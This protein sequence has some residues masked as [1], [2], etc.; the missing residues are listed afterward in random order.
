MKIFLIL[1]L[2][3]FLCFVSKAQTTGSVTPNKSKAGADS[4]KTVEA[5]CGECR[6]GMKGGG[7]H[8]AVRIDG[9][10]YFVDGT[11]IDKHGDAHADDGFCNKIREA[12]VSGTV[13][14]DRFIATSFTLLRE[15]KAKP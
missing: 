12:R 6:F 3:C 10:A 8:L 1:T 5:A 15:K 2:S 4:L 7:C 9:K 13:V 14:N 11:T